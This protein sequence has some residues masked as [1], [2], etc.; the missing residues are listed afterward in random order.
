MNKDDTILS[1][2]NLAI[3]YDERTIL[4]NISMKIS[5]GKIVAIMGG[6]G[7]GKTTL[8]KTIIGQLPA[9]QG[10]ITM[11]NKKMDSTSQKENKLIR[12]NL[13]VLFQHGALFSDLNVFENVAFPVVEHNTLPKNKLVDI[14]LEKLNSVGL[15]AAAHLPISKISGGM[16]KRVALAR[17]M[18][19]NPKIMLYDEPFSGLDPISTDII[20]KLIKTFSIQTKCASIIITHDVKKTFEIADMVYIIDQENLISSGTPSDLTKSDNLYV[21]QFIQGNSKNP[22]A[23]H[24]PETIEFKEWLKKQG[25]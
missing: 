11:L 7:A 1:I 13:G 8:L 9:K 5:K 2:D 21:K 19:L 6:S 12:K 23:F 20:A 22:L 3:G 15:R 14:V 24:Y 4:K 10:S 18:M 17:A 16:S 25:N